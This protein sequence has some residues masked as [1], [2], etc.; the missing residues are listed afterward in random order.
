MRNGKV[1]G[2]GYILTGTKRKDEK[3]RENKELTQTNIPKFIVG[4]PGGDREGHKKKT[5]EDLTEKRTQ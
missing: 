3:R 1:E 5:K 2:G 4:R